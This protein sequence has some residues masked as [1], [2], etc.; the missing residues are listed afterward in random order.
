MSFLLFIQFLLAVFLLMLARVLLKGVVC[1]RRIARLARAIFRVAWG[2]V[3]MFIFPDPSNMGLMV[4]SVRLV[5][6]TNLLTM[7]GI[8]GYSSGRMNIEL[9]V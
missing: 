8:L 2:S 5:G 3:R 1:V 9:V 6:L 4:L 7:N